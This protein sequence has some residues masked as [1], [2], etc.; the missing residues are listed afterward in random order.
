MYVNLRRYPKVGASKEAIERSVRDELLPELRK[1]QGFEGYCAFWDE[2][3]AEVSVSV[4][5]D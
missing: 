1:Q 3:G 2:E 5:A 4:F